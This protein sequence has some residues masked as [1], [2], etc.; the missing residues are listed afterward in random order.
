MTFAEVD[1][2][3]PYAQEIISL[4]GELYYLGRPSRGIVRVPI[5]KLGLERSFHYEEKGEMKSFFGRVEGVSSNI[6]E[7]YV[8]LVDRKERRVKLPASLYAATHLEKNFG[9]FVPTMHK[10]DGVEDLSD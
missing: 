1:N 9:V 6:A 10:I 5:E 7:T 3:G 8:A 4:V 2:T